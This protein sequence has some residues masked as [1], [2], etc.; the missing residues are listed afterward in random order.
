MKS[1]SGN[2]FRCPFCGGE[3]KLPRQRFAVVGCQCCAFPIVDGI[4]LLRSVHGVAPQVPVVMLTGQRDDRVAAELMK[5]GAADYLSKGTLTPERLERSL[6]HAIS[7]ADNR[8]MLHVLRRLGEIHR[9]SA[10]H[11]VLTVEFERRH[12][13]GRMALA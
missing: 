11:G 7:L 8:R 1:K 9:R 3:I 4:S 12:A 2:I 10:E 13:L 6:R 5:A